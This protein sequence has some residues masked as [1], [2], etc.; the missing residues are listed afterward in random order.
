[1]DSSEYILSH[2]FQKDSHKEHE[3]RED[4]KERWTVVVRGRILLSGQPQAD[5][6]LHLT[7]NVL[8]LLSGI[9][10]FPR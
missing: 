2:F 3:E 6:Y 5:Q 8:V 4:H 7:T 10:Y 9:Y 1:M